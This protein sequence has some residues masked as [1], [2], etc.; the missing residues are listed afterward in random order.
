[1]RLAGKLASLFSLPLNPPPGPHQACWAYKIESKYRARDQPVTHSPKPQ[2]FRA[3]TPRDKGTTPECQN[4]YPFV[5][6]DRDMLDS[7]PPHV[8][9]RWGT[10]SSAS[11]T[12]K[13]K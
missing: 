12:T 11:T 5:S 7:S 8:L 4:L 2:S 3:P 10:R 13:P 1:M 6:S 9:A